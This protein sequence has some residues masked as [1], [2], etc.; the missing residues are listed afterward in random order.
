MARDL[1]NRESSSFGIEVGYEGRAS[2]TVLTGEGA[3][4]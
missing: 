1:L 4:V 3:D 2:G